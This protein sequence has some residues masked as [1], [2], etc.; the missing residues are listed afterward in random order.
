MLQNKPSLLM[1]IVFGKVT[2]YSE[3]KR[4]REINKLMIKYIDRE[5]ERQRER[6]RETGGDTERQSQRDR[7]R[8]RETERQRQKDRE[9]SR[10]IDTEPQ[11]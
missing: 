8:D 4:E 5:R 10:Q 1:I 6:E 3:K 2:R 11:R 7:D 9:G